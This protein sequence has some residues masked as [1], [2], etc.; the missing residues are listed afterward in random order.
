M[1]RK[2]TPSLKTNLISQ[3]VLAFV[4][5]FL[6]VLCYPNFN[7]GFLA[8]IALIPLFFAIEN[9]KSKTRF[10]TGY[11]F[12]IIF[13]AGILYWL[14]NVTVPGTI[15]TVLILAFLPAIFCLL[16]SPSIASRPGS[17]V[18]LPCA[19]VLTEYLRTYIFS[20]FP[21]A[22]LGYSQS[23]N[24]PVIQIADITGPYGVSFLIVLVNVG[25][26]LAL[27]RKPKRFYILFFITV[28]FALVLVYGDNRIK[29][30]YPAKLLKV[31]VIQ[32]NIPQ[33]MKW[34]PRYREFIL[35]KYKMLTQ[36]ALKESPG[37]VVWPETAVPG[38]LDEP[39]LEKQ[40]TNL[41]KSGNAYLLVGTL[42]EVG[43]KVFN[44]ATLISNKGEI[45]KS[46][47]KIHLV[48]FGEFIPFEKAF[49]W[50]RGVIDKPIG[51]FARG[52]EFTVFK[53]NL[54]KVTRTTS[55]IQ[56]SMEF[57]SFSTLVCFEDIFPDLC[58]KFVKKGARFLVNITNDAWFGKSPAL[59]QHAQG[60]VFRAVE[61]RVP[62]IRAA[63]TGFS[64]IIDHR[65]KILKS[66][67]VGED[68]ISVDGYAVEVIMP[69]F[70]K[71]IYTRFGDVFSWLCIAYV[72]L[73]LWRR[74]R[75]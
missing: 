60:S 54:E 7:L 16:A 14:A 58:R 30:A 66:V 51:N 43:S 12:G 25:I 67:K 46:Y 44:S 19:W 31:A 2:I 34:D 48:P 29:R 40:I 69:T 28:L 74:R 6:L 4:S 71:T 53:F 9:K 41:A 72:L 37:L 20:G 11:L 22:L 1:L 57:H 55:K 18:F 45:L 33:E 8:W 52:N 17:V 36:V 27:R 64:C 38:Y 35:N 23:P 15:A 65:G 47:N 73:G 24:L 68:E 61:N 5:A 13:F 39:D 56:K 50:M 59:Y 70:I 21:W 3:L 62:V 32:G 10:F 49:L 26:Y 63:N 75:P 42:K